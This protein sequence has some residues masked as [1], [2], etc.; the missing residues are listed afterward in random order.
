MQ[1][2]HNFLCDSCLLLA[3]KLNYHL[4][5]TKG[6]EVSFL[7]HVLVYPALDQLS[8]CSISDKPSYYHGELANIL[9]WIRELKVEHGTS[10]GEFYFS[11]F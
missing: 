11:Q 7:P 3:L 10:R 9:F 4:I 8:I 6:N 2:S 1:S 5:A